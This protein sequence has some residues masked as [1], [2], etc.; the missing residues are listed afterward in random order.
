MAIEWDIERVGDFIFKHN[1]GSMFA[2]ARPPR[3]WLSHLTRK[4]GPRQGRCF[5]NAKMFAMLAP[6]KY[7]YVEGLAGRDKRGFGVVPHGWVVHKDYPDFAFD[8][9]WDVSR[10]KGIE[11]CMYLG[12]PVEVEVA[13]CVA[14]RQWD[15]VK[16]GKLPD[17]AGGYSMLSCER[18][19]SGDVP[20]LEESQAYLREKFGRDLSCR[21]PR[22]RNINL[23]YTHAIL[24]NDCDLAAFR[25]DLRMEADC[26]ENVFL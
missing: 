20:T 25:H 13:M 3:H 17:K 22:Y 26:H 16:E 8:L 9:T 12:L 18:F 19:L 10:S 5:M 24:R 21:G 15:L 4:L 11:K 23:Y 2:H 6:D 14:G 1:D 7:W